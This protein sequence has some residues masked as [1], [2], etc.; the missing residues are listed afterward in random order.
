[1]LPRLMMCETEAMSADEN[2][3]YIH[4]RMGRQRKRSK[5]EKGKLL[6]ENECRINTTWNAGNKKALSKSK[7]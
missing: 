2:R 4:K 5:K 3:K 6:D 7:V 1:M